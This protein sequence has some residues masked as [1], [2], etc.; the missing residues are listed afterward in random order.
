MS[1][2]DFWP[3]Y[4]LKRGISGKPGENLGLPETPKFPVSRGV[5]NFG[6]NASPIQCHL[7]EDSVNIWFNWSVISI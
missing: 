2:L 7:I 4:G 1:S 6:E 5:K 3:I